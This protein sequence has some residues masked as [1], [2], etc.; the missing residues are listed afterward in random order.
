MSIKNIFYRGQFPSKL[1]DIISSKLLISK[2]EA[3]QLINL[4]SVYYLSNKEYNIENY[5]KY[6]EDLKTSDSLST[7]DQSLYSKVKASRSL[8]DLEVQPNDF[9]KVYTDP[10]R[11]PIANIIDWKNQVLAVTPNYLVVDKPEGV[12]SHA[13][14]DNFRENLVEKIRDN[15]EEIDKNFYITK[16]NEESIENNYNNFNEKKKLKKEK[17]LNKIFS[18]NILENRK[19]ENLILPQRLDSDTGGLILIVRKNNNKIIKKR[20][21]NTEKRKIL[22]DQIKNNDN[23]NILEKNINKKYYAL[24]SFQFPSSLILN[25]NINNNKF[26]LFLNNYNNSSIKLENGVLKIQNLNVEKVPLNKKNETKLFNF[27][28]INDILTSYLVSSP[29]SPKKYY[30]LKHEDN[31]AIELNEENLKAN[32]EKSEARN[33]ENDLLECQLRIEGISNIIYKTKTEWKKEFD[34]K[35]IQE[36]PL[37]NY[38][39]TFENK[40]PNYL[41]ENF[42]KKYSTEEFNQYKLQLAMNEWLNSYNDELQEES[43]NDCIGFVEVKVGLLTG[44]THQIRGQIQA[45]QRLRIEQEGERE[46]KEFLDLGIHLAGDRLYPGA[47]SKKFNRDYSYVCPF[48]CLKVSFNYIIYF[49]FSFLIFL[50]VL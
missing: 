33:E 36:N 8:I 21:K 38:F 4:G 10:K 26:N 14:L 24:I 37:L 2:E 42:N 39:E 47:T 13:I 19:N 16:K 11:Y 25:N 43:K 15:I 23:N 5:Q 22:K 32:Q 41:L 35:S 34:L 46:S 40:K 27:L 29:V 20:E 30:W 1:S 28:S 49:I 12:P 31:E 45:M 50:L 6:E 9:I 17:K 3:L 7:L 18:S 44:R 48:L